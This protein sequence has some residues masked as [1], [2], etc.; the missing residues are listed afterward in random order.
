VDAFRAEHVAGLA[1]KSRSQY[2]TVIR[3]VARI[4]DPVNL[5]DLD[6]RAASRLAA[7]LRS[8]GLS[9]ESTRSYLVL[10]RAG[11]NWAAANGMLDTVPAV[12]LP[13]RSGGQRVMKGR[14]I[15]REEFERMLDAVQVDAAGRR[16]AIDPAEYVRAWRWD[17]ESLWLSGLR[18]AEAGGLRWYSQ[19]RMSLE[20]DGRRSRYWIP[21][22]AQKSHRNAV[23]PI[24]PDFAEHL[25]H[26]PR[27]DR[28]RAVFRF[29]GST[30]RRLSA[31]SAGDRIREF[32]RLAGVVVRRFEHSDRIKY[33]SAHDL[34]RAFGQRWFR[35]VRPHQL[36]RMMRHANLDTTL[37]FYTSAESDDFADQ[38]W[39]L[40]E[41][42]NRPAAWK[43]CHDV[44]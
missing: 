7:S 18:L 41:S 34:R 9:E 22:E 19:N 39:T 14:P 40:H 43:I 30:G 10:F 6:A 37:R 23:C 12:R 4:L 33:A 17:L 1:A 20:L 2:G 44:D 11:L 32:G 28:G 13:V 21:A 16:L 3:H 38:L 8:G 42:R 26:V 25:E 29:M 24:P 27:G 36:A 15:T 31:A 5:T 35:R